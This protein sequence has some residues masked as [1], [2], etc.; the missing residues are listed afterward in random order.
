MEDRR[1]QRPQGGESH[2]QGEKR[3]EN[4][5]QLMKDLI[6]DVDDDST[7]DEL[8]DDKATGFLDQDE[9]EFVRQY[10]TLFGMIRSEAKK[11][12]IPQEEWQDSNLRNKFLR[13][14]KFLTQ[15]S[16]SKGGVAMK[17]L[18]TEKVEQSQELYET[19]GVSEEEADL[20]DK[21]MNKVK[22][23]GGTQVVGDV[24]TGEYTGGNREAW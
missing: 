9:L 2:L 16:K 22:G 11:I 4:L 10:Q 6:T 5:H 19:R 15:T 23:G 18:K 21:I 20:V 8:T 12:G 13:D 14:M 7:Q 24:N 17:L 1:P 3:V